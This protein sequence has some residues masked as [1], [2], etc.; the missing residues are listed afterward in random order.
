GHVAQRLR[1]GGVLAAAVGGAALFVWSLRA[2]GTSAVLDGIRRVGAG[3]IVIL[4]LGG[5][6]GLV[7][8]AAWRL[9]LDRE[10]QPSLPAIFSA[11]LAGDAIGNITPF[12]FLI[13]EPSK[14]VLVRRLIEVPASVAALTVENLCYSGTVVVVLVAGTIALLVSFAVPQAL[15]IASLALLGS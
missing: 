5:L 13:S 2:A 4:F 14:I 3:M 1:T 12:G 8:A 10:H 7:R 11:Y 6:R 9:C 15:Q